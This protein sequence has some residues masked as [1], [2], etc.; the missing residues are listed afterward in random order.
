M[1][2]HNGHP[3]DRVYEYDGAFKCFACGGMWGAVSDPKVS[4]N[5]CEAAP[6]A[7]GCETV[8]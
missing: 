7:L 5:Y 1:N 2:G 3:V 8:P 6:L 4:P